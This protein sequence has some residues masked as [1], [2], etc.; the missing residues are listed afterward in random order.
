MRIVNTTTIMTIV[1]SYKVGLQL[2][3]VIFSHLTYGHE[4]RWKR[5]S[6]TPGYCEIF[7]VSHGRNLQNSKEKKKNILTS[8]I[9]QEA[10]AP[11]SAKC[12]LGN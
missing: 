7:S 12:T 8:D 2:S 5:T 1:S 11:V 4:S 9:N 6:Y 3:R 10:R